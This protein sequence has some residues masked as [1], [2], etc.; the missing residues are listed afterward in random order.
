MGRAEDIAELR[1]LKDSPKLSPEKKTLVLEKLAALED[2]NLEGWARA[3]G[4]KADSAPVVPGEL[5]LKG[6]IGQEGPGGADPAQAEAE[7][8][9]GMLDPRFS[10]VP[11]VLALQ[12]ATND[13]A[14]DQAARAKFEAG[15]RDPIVV[16]E[17]PVDVVRKHLLENPAMLRALRPDDPPTLDEIASLDHGSELYQTA[18]D[19]MFRKADEAA[20]AG[21]RKIVRYSKTPWLTLDPKELQL[22]VQ[23]AAPELANRAQAF[24]LGVDDMAAVGVGRAASEIGGQTTTLTQPRLGVNET[25]EH[26]TAEVNAWTEEEYPLEYGAGQVV[27]MLSP[28]SVFNKLWDGVRSGGGW[29]AQA[30]AKTRLGGLAASAPAPLKAVAGIAGD[31]ATGAVAAGAGQVAQEGVDAAARGAL[32]DFNEAGERIVGTAKT[33]GYLSAGGSLAGRLAHL[34]ADHIRDTDRFDGLV[35]RTEPNLDW[36]PSTAI[37]GPRLSP[38]TR[39]VVKT[40]REGNYVPSDVLAEELSGPLQRAAAENSKVARG[41]ATSARRNVYPTPEG[42][43]P[44]PMTHLQSASLERMRDH[45]QP[46]PNGGLHPVD[47]KFRPAAKVFNSLIEDVST[48]P[49]EGASK[50]TPD[51]AG[52][53]LNARARY[54]LLKNDI[55]AAN[56]RAAGAGPRPPINR[57]DYLRTIKDSRARAAADEEIEA[58]IEDIVGDVT[59][60]PARRAKVEQQVLQEL[61]D[62]ASFVEA[63]GSLGDYLRQRG[64]EAVYVKPRAYDARRSDRLTE[65]LGDAELVEAAKLDRQRR[66]LGGQKGGYDQLIKK[67]EEDVAKAETVEKRV[68]PGGD[69][70]RPVARLATATPGEKQLL[71][72]V[73]ALAD[74]AGVR[75][76]LDRYRGLQDTINVHNRARFRGPNNERLGYFNAQNQTDVGMLRAFPLLKA[77]EG[78]LGPLR[79]GNPGKAALLGGGETDAQQR[80]AESSAR[81][82]YEAAR[83]RRLKEIEQEKAAEERER[84][85]R[86]TETIRRRR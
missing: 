31:A 5:G 63:H 72:N 41:R 39:Q 6:I 38:E 47:D 60:T 21:G 8:V 40:A 22:K 74:Q 50:L 67:G 78:P 1:A 73:R 65:G 10:L 17:P 33:G 49:I 85:R 55:E 48:A 16:Y 82:R 18:S 43:A 56:A 30:A 46:Q 11:Q 80:S 59:P 58:S 35:R 51:E 29:L 44:L 70:F 57:E 34:G 7:R 81:S 69:A 52:T 12:P 66:T 71:D 26:P 19:Y 14:G 37:T 68:A 36:S 64:I 23:A 83:E 27:G 84:E 76:Q 4:T 42:A 20:T 28:R 54:K 3:G 15:Q 62:E 45:H 75:E 2:Q 79:G 13:P 9:A 86:K 24:I 53:F 77:L 25:A 32:P 61:V